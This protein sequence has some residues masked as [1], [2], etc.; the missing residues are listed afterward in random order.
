MEPKARRRRL[1][2][3]ALGAWAIYLVAGNL[4]VATPIGQ[5]LIAP[6]PERFTI[7]WGRAWTVL[8]GLVHVRDLKIRQ[9]SQDIVW[10]LTI[11]RAVTGINILAL[12]F[13]TF[14]AVL[15]R[16]RGVEVEVEKAST[17]MPPTGKTKPGF[18]ILLS[19]TGVKDIR[20]MDFFGI[21]IE[22][23]ELRIGGGL[24][25]TARG[26][27]GIPRARVRIK[28]G[29]VTHEGVALATDFNLDCRARID[30]HTKKDRSEG[31]IFPFISGSLTASGDI[32]DLQFI[33]TF[34]RSISWM[35]VRG[36]AGTL[37]ADLD[38][39]KGTL[40]PGSRLDIQTSAFDFEYLDY[41]V[42]GKG[43]VMITGREADGRGDTELDFELDDFGL[44][45]A[46]SETPHIE[47]NDLSVKI[48]G[49]LG[50]MIQP[51]ATVEVTIDIP[52]SDIPDLRLY[53]R[54]F[55]G[56][57]PVEI[58]SG[59]G[60][61]RSHLEVQ[62]GP[63]TG[64]G[65]IEVKTTN[66]SIDLKDRKVVADVHLLFPI[67]ITDLDNRIFTVDGS[68]INVANAGV[69]TPEE[70]D[71]A[72]TPPRDWWCDIAVPEGTLRLAQPLDLDIDV[73]LKAFDVEPLLALI[74][75]TRKSADRLDRILAIHD[76]E[77]GAHLTVGNSG[78]HIS[79]LFA[80]GGRAEM[81]GN[82]C[83]RKGDNSGAIYIKYGILSLGVEILGEDEKKHI[84]TPRK[85][86][87]EY[88][89]K[90]SCG[91]DGP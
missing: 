2:R 59:K 67:T 26:P 72:D 66:V 46:D 36:G 56:A 8:P 64:G 73:T 9:H 77:G 52:E 71:P 49:N 23:E 31:G 34:L 10:H 58:L 4:F 42:T 44:S 38:I 14:H 27:L 16:V 89:G 39:S 40:Q 29:Q 19:G 81:L 90:F 51:D 61:L 41:T 57:S 32:A 21:H 45:F 47:G 86:Y 15:P 85:W 35:Q 7:H 5:N 37:E 25:T 20:F 33:S 91:R 76:L 68:T 48:I 65:T 11:D 17:T 1:V 80:E 43:K 13:K 62:T 88:V 28:T 87:D 78:T 69:G 6:H 63:G 50:Q 18:R 30:K 12:P 53:N 54:Y 24:D 75:K 84:I 3:L 55:K 83:L 79:D 60:R 70:K 82:L 74:S 22:G